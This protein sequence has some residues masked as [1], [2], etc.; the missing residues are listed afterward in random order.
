[1]EEGLDAKNSTF[2][3]EDMTYDLDDVDIDYSD[4]VSDYYLSSVNITLG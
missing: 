3:D 1:M 4:I 2:A